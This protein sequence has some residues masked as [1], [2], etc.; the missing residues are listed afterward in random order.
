M[1][2]ENPLKVAMAALKVGGVPAIAA[3]ADDR[4]NAHNI[5]DRIGITIKTR[6]RIGAKGFEIYRTK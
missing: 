4:L 2:K 1:R 6:Q 5:A 3:T